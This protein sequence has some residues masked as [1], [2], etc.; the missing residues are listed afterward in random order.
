MN[1][2]STIHHLS[3]SYEPS[4]LQAIARSEIQYFVNEL[5]CVF[6]QSYRL[7]SSLSAYLRYTLLFHP[8]LSGI[9]R[10]IWPKRWVQ[11]PISNMKSLT[12]AWKVGWLWRLC[13]EIKGSS[14]WLVSCK[15]TWRATYIFCTY[16]LRNCNNIS[17][18]T[19]STTRRDLNLLLGGGINC[20]CTSV[21]TRYMKY[22][23]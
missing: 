3:K 12:H 14:R 11:S 15:I 4:T 13:F 5:R 21:N 8:L 22:L 2:L 9:L 16:S 1:W 17:V 20:L 7:A 10:K 23:R 6:L 19:T 18:C